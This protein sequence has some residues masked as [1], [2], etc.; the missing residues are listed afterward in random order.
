MY[1]VLQINRVERTLVPPDE[2]LIEE[3]AHQ[4]AVALSHQQD[5]NATMQKLE[6]LNEELSNLQQTKEIEHKN[7]IV[8]IR[9]DSKANY[10]K[11]LNAAKQISSHIEFDDLY[12]YV[13]N[14]LTEI[15]NGDASNLYLISET[16]G[17][18]HLVIQNK[19][20]KIDRSSIVGR[21]VSNKEYDC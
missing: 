5:Q 20:F 7:Q 8:A 1:S 16:D 12:N 11:M 17:A 3:F 9:N 18:K 2:S 6:F 14:D 13:I 15:L 10:E 19:M 4:I 21:V